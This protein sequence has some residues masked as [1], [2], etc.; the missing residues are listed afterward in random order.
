MMVTSGS[1][2]SGDTGLKICINKLSAELIVGLSPHR[3]PSGTAISVASKKPVNTVFRL[4]RIWSMYV[5]L[6]VYFT[7]RISASGFLASLTALRFSW[8]S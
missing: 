5:G 8:R 4:V 7:R 2:A 6:P 3:M 1:H